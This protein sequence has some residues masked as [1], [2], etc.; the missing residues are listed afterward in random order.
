MNTSVPITFF[1][2]LSFV[3]HLMLLPFGFMPPA[4]SPNSR[5]I[6]VAY[7]S[8]SS[9]AV[10]PQSVPLKKSSDTATDSPQKRPVVQHIVPPKKQ[11]NSTVAVKKTKSVTLKTETKPA[12]QRSETRIDKK[13]DP[14][15]K[16]VEDKTVAIDSTK[17][18]EVEVVEEVQAEL[19]LD[20]QFS[21]PLPEPVSQPSE[22]YPVEPASLLTTD[23]K[24]SSEGSV[25]GQSSIA[26][27]LSAPGDDVLNINDSRQGFRDALPHYD[28]NPP[29][30]YPEVAKLRGWEGKVILKAKILKNGRVGR[31]KIMT[32]SGY[33]S[34]DNAA[35]KAISRWTFSPAT[36]F[37]V[38]VDSMVEIPVSFS[39]KDL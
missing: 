14:L 18:E 21:E 28:D 30:R 13:V 20:V 27:Q 24:E 32:S 16:I 8:R 7:V 5:A 36:T 39:L 34:L 9:D 4:P 11:K 3:L 2:L 25:Q 10:F 6:G 17:E 29:P 37:G 33:R 19:P 1:I 22:L 35:R 26:S 12:Y 23:S 31:L 38:P 15:P